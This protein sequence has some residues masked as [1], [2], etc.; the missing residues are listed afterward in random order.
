[1]EG[2]VNWASLPTDLIFSI[3]SHLR[4][5][6]DFVCF[7]AV[8]T[9]WR[10]TMQHMNHAFFQ[11]WLMASRFLEDEYSENVLFY[12][13]STLKTIK[14]C[15]P[16]TKGRCVAASGSGH[17]IG[18]DKDDDLSA[19]L[20]NPLTGKT[21]LLPRLPEFFHNNGAHGWVSGD[22][23]A[24]TIELNNWMSTNMALWH[25]G[26]GITMEAWATVP[27]RMFRLRESYYL[28]MLAAMIVGEVEIPIHDIDNAI[29]L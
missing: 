26:G 24:I 4:E 8:C 1:M 14:V 13:L 7:R 29:V 5:P 21:T 28:Q 6:E 2:A 23:G 16:A 25:H 11:P 17:L 3:S 27:K 15:V 10:A 9:Q 22:A 18:V 19:V 12:S 20:V